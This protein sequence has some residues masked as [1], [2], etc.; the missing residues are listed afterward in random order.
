MINGPSPSWAWLEKC[1]LNLPRRS[2]DGCR[3]FAERYPQ[4]A[5]ASYEYA[6]GLWDRG[7]EQGRELDKIEALLRHAI[8]RAP[9]WYQPHYQ[10]GLLYESKAQ[11]DH[12]IREMQKV[13]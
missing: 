3:I 5:A 13:A 7:G 11:P 8:E 12:A 2:I 4:N 10:L 1:L 9:Q 6:V